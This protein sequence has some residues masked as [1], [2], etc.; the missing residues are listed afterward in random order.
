MIEEDD[1]GGGGDEHICT[2]AFS[3]GASESILRPTAS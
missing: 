1:S 3:S 2:G